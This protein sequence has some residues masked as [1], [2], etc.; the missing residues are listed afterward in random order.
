MSN[1]ETITRIATVF[2]AA[3]DYFDAPALSFW[4]RFGQKT[5]D[6]LALQVGGSSS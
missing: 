3:S 1:E 2:N 5:I 6:Q 4:D